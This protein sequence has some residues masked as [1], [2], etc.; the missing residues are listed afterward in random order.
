MLRHV[1][2]REIHISLVSDTEVGGLKEARDA[3]NN[4]IISDSTLRSLFTPQLKKCHQDTK[5]CVVT[6]V[7]YLPKLYI[8]QITWRDCY[9]KNS[10]IKAKNTKTEGLRKKKTHI[11]KTYKNTVW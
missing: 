2:V 1:S 10:S 8:H 7:L 3:E 5:S 6:S 4:I 11:Y 9:L